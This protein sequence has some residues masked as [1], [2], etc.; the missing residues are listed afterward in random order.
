MALVVTRIGEGPS[1]PLGATRSG[2][3]VN[4]SVLSRHATGMELLL[5]DAA[6]DARPA[7]VIRIDP[8][9]NRTYHYW[10]VF[11]PGVRPGQI[12]GSRVEGRCDHAR[13]LRFSGDKPEGGGERW[14]RWIDT[15]LDSPYDIVPWQAAPSLSVQT[16]RAEA[17]S[18]AVLYATTGS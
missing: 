13:G 1:A 12:Y 2:T 7:R 9:A 4:F 11:V 8:A 5:F 6:H 3:G 10:H 16:Y 14:R 17:R 15:A 18:V